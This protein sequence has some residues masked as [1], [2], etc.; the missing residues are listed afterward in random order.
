MW[1]SSFAEPR[2][3]QWRDILEK[4]KN[5]IPKQLQNLSEVLMS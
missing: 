2:S 3:T 1:F 5:E 4:E